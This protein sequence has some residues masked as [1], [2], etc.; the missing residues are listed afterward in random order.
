MNNGDVN[1]RSYIG[2]GMDTFLFFKPVCNLTPAIMLKKKI[3]ETFRY[4]YF[5]YSAQPLS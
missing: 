3:I 1:G 5:V 2:M 4:K